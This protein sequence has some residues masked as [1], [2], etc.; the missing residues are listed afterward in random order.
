MRRNGDDGP[1]ECRQNAR[2]EER[3][4]T[5]HVPQRMS[6]SDGPQIHGGP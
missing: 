6:L 2:S 4:G 5:V 3:S 1:E